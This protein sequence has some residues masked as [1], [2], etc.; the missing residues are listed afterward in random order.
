MKYKLTI[1]LLLQA[2]LLTAQME[3]RYSLSSSMSFKTFSDVD[4]NFK[5]TPFINKDLRPV[6]I[7]G[8]KETDLKARYNAHQDYFEVLRKGQTK[9]FTVKSPLKLTFVYTNKVYAAFNKSEN[10]NEKT[11]YVIKHEDPSF[12]I[13]LKE[14]ILL[15][16]EVEAKTGYGSYTPP[17]FK[18]KKDTNFVK[19]KNSDEV[20]EIPTKTKKFLEIVSNKSKEVKTFI[21]KNKLKL[22]KEKDLIKIFKYYTSLK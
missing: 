6:T 3:N 17:T 20:I 12:K 18:R 1:L 15:K 7:E 10:Q 11:F 21:K 9:Y 13:L 8:Y 2:L 4:K 16:E 5:G 19:F 14:N 22:K